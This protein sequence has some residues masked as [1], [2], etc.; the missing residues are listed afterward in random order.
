MANKDNF[1]YL[2]LSRQKLDEVIE[3]MTLFNEA[4]L[5]LDQ[6][7]VVSTFGYDT[8]HFSDRLVE[9]Q[10]TK[11]LIDKQFDSFFSG[12]TSVVK[13]SIQCFSM[14]AITVVAAF[15]GSFT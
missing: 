1:Y 2:K 4:V 6:D 11:A 8:N 3:W 13:S 15:A 14:L 9:L 10:R 12:G 5:D 7:T